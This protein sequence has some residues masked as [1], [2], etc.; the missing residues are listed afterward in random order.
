MSTLL[1]LNKG[2]KNVLHDTA[3]CPEL[4]FYYL[5]CYHRY[6]NNCMLQIRLCLQRWI[7]LIDRGRYDRSTDMRTTT[8]IKSRSLAF[9]SDLPTIRST[10]L[11]LSATPA[12]DTFSSQCGSYPVT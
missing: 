5:S 9:Y 1:R 12:D 2:F 4:I 7:Q 6:T 3:V 11:S 10:G 8:T